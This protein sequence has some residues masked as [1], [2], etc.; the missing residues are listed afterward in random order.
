MNPLLPDTEGRSPALSGYIT[1]QLI[2][3]TDPRIS[4]SGTQDPLQNYFET[5]PPSPN[6]SALTYTF[7]G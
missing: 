2:T 5:P 6:Y 7:N 1:A 3:A 4:Y